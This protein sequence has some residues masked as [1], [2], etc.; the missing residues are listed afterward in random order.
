MSGVFISYRRSDSQGWA[1]RLGAD[2]A[3]AFGESARFFD[4]HSIELGANFLASIARALDG[5]DAVLVL[6]GPQWATLRD[7]AGRRRLEAPDDVV[8]AEVA[9]ALSL[10][11]PVIPVLLGGAAMPKAADLPAALQGLL[12]RNALE[13]SD[14][15]WS[16]D[17]DR[18]FD[19]LQ[20]QTPLRRQ[21]GAGAAAAA[22]TV[23]VGAG[24]SLRDAEVGRVT[25]VR[26]A[27]PG[28]AAPAVEVLRG[29]QLQ[30]VKIG[31][32]TGV[33]FSPPAE[34]RR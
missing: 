1:G 8:A 3:A 13:L 14:S 10:T 23:S 9:Q 27:D 2:L 33:E 34:P 26:G 6:I 11:V 5:A 16:H 28:Q 32:L 31:D 15:R 22:T 12:A 25:G 4:L 29:A 21:P 30:N 7:D 24:L 19:A 17:C 18:L 20:A